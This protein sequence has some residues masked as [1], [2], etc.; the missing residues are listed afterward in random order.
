[1]LSIQPKPPN[2]P[3]RV[4]FLTL[5]VCIALGSFLAMLGLMQPN[6]PLFAHARFSLSGCPT[7]PATAAA[8][9]DL[10]TAIACFNTINTAGTGFIF[11]GWSGDCSGTAECIL[12]IDTPK[13]I[14]AVF[15][16]AAYQALLPIVLD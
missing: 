14:S 7:F 10:N 13:T 2:L 8:E 12:T 4:P 3:D 1:M 11:T 15:A 9:S 6:R 16:E 5:G